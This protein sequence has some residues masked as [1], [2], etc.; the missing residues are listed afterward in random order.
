MI[1][2]LESSEIKE[3]MDIWLETNIKAHSFIQEKYWID[4]Y[5]VV[6]EQ[7]MPISKT[8]VY[9]ENNIIKAFISIINNSF[10]GALFVLKEYQGQGIGIKL[11]NYCK[12]IYPSLE[13][14]VYAENISAVDFYKN[15]GFVIKSEQPNGDS[16]FKEYIMLWMKQ[17]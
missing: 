17:E 8:F 7:Y 12:S 16:G 5:N 3:V 13:L 2:V 9:K 6:K 14:A 15:C 1:K 10:I 4:N 11:L